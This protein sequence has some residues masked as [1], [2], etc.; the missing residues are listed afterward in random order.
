MLVQLVAFIR[1]AAGGAG[2]YLSLS[3]LHSNVTEAV[4][5]ASVSAVGMVGVL[6]FVSHVLLH[7]QDAKRIG[8]SAKNVDFQFEVGFA[9]LAFGVVAI[10]SYFLNW[11][12]HA[13]T[14][15]LLAYA[16]YLFQA[17]ILHTAKSL[18]GK[19]IDMVHLLRGGIITFVYSGT[20]FYIAF[21][22]IK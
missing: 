5:I 17:G 19:K 15:L 6:S 1:Y 22:A 10:M 4:A 21:Q 11:G 13:N 7:T 14:A 12:L 9:N 8:F 20:M 2:L 16:F 18:F 3:Y